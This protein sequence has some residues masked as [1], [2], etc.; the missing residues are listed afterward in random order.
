M[1]HSPTLD[2][3]RPEIANLYARR[4]S[5]IIFFLTLFSKRSSLC[6]NLI[7]GLKYI[8]REKEKRL[9]G[10]TSQL[11]NWGVSRRRAI[12]RKAFN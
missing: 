1:M 2:I 4:G 7:N 12:K 5:S 10:V 3:S 6:S 11:S 8:K 9:L